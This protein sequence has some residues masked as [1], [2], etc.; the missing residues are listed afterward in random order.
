MWAYPG[1]GLPFSPA[2]S[3]R[4][5]DTMNRPDR[6]RPFPLPSDLG[7]QST[8]AATYLARAGAAMLRGYVKK[9]PPARIAEQLWSRDN[10]TP[11]ILRAATT[12]ATTTTTGWAAELARV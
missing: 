8:R 6:D 3:R 9:L 5:G 4:R 10:V 1:W 11:E 7:L 2:G 12:P